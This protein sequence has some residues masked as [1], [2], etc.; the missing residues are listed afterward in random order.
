[1]LKSFF[2]KINVDGYGYA[3]E[4]QLEQLRKG[5]MVV[6]EN[7]YVGK[8]Y[9]KYVGEEVSHNEMQCNFTLLKLQEYMEVVEEEGDIQIGD[10]FYRVPNRP[11]KNQKVLIDGRLYEVVAITK[12]KGAKNNVMVKD[13]MDTV[14]SVQTYHRLKDKATKKLHLYVKEYTKALRLL[15]TKYY[16]G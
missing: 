12:Q 2:K 15:G 14:H 6:L 8:T 13:I 4:Y 3:N 5:D 7:D 1:M 10:K 11:S 16:L 9:V